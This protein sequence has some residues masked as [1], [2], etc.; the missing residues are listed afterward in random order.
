MRN[1]NALTNSGVVVKRSILEQ[2][3]G[4]SEG[5]LTCV[6]DFD[7]WLKISRV[8]EKFTYIPNTLGAYWLGNGK[9]SEPSRIIADRTKFVYHKYFNF[10]KEDD[11]KQSEMVLCYLLGRIKRILGLWKEALEF[12]KVSVKSENMKFKLRSI[13]W[14]LLLNF[15]IKAREVKKCMLKR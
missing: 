12:F 4:L 11:R 13:C 2:V 6:E 10:L 3:G 7:L 14:I 1:E 5:F 8:T 9:V 15:F